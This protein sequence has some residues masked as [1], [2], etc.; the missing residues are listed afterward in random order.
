MP[1][2]RDRMRVM[3]AQ[4]DGGLDAGAAAVELVVCRSNAGRRQGDRVSVGRG[5]S[6]IAHRRQES[7]QDFSVFADGHFV[8]T[9]DIIPLDRAGQTT[10][11]VSAGP[12]GPLVS[13]PLSGEL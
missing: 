12:P 1:T 3:P 4:V 9:A 7:R 6:G 11:V 5:K 2:L 13:A 8:P 10:N